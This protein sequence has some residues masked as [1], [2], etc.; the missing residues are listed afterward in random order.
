MNVRARPEDFTPAVMHA[1]M[2]TP[3]KPYCLLN[4]IPK[5]IIIILFSPTSLNWLHSG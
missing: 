4:K 3:R 5:Q 1:C 2:V